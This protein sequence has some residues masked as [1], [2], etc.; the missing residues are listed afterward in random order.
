MVS[1][2]SVCTINVNVAEIPTVV[3]GS[4]VCTINVM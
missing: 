4:S 3:S 2:S 1:G